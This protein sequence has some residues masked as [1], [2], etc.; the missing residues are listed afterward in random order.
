MALGMLLEMAA[1]NGDRVAIG[2]RTAGMT[3]SELLD[4]A[5]VGGSEIVR[6]GAYRVAF[7]GVNGPA[8]P[9]TL[10]SGALAGIPVTPLNYRLSSDQLT[11]QIDRIGQPLIVADQDVIHRVP[12]ARGAINSDAWLEF[13]TSSTVEEL[14]EVSDD[15]VAVTLFT[16]GTTSRPKEVVLRHSHLVAYV[17]QTVEFASATEH[18]AAL[19]SLPPY[20]VAGVGTVLTNLYAGRRIVYLPNFSPEEWLATVRNEKVTS[21]L[22]VPTMLQRIVQYL[23]GADGDVP[24]LRSIAYGGAKMP[25]AV[26]QRAL[27]S[28]PHTDFTNA[29]GL[30]ETSSTIAVLSPDDHRAALASDDERVRARLASAGRLVPGVEGVIRDMGGYPLGP[31]QIGELWVRGAQVSG[32]YE[33]SDSVLDDEGWFPTRDRAWFDEDGYLFVEGRAD[34]TIIRGGEN[35]APAEIEEVLSDHPAVREVAVLGTPDDHWGQRITAVVVAEDTSNPD[36]DEMLEWVRAKLRSS[37]CPDEVVFTEELPYTHTGKLLR[38]ELAQR[39]GSRSAS[40]LSDRR[41]PRKKN[42]Q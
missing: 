16:S 17:L 33:H 4:S 39:L 8:F 14:P 41:R 20:H 34:D 6:R 1:A 30:T 23:G 35:I 13:V 40:R 7:I 36:P 42:E 31:G 19:V 12:G 25:R 24:S 10:L 27:E 28:F 26:L 15:A 32:E 22:L 11:D 5:R 9:V 21:A 37:R 2:S 29:Y 38:R 18:D 3:V